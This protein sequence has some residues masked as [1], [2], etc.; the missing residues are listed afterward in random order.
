M[1]VGWPI[2]ITNFII[3]LTNIC[4]F[5]PIDSTTYT[6]GESCLKAV[7]LLSPAQA[8]LS[9]VTSD[10][11]SGGSMRRMIDLASGKS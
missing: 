8:S 5:C 10:V 1:L 7:S 2:L 9:S 4:A 11:I 6:P 3:V